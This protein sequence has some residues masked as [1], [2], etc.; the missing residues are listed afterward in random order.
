[1]ADEEVQGRQGAPAQT[2][3]APQD[4]ADAQ[5]Q[6]AEADGGGGAPLF[7]PEGFIMMSIAGAIDITGITLLCF[8][9]DDFGITDLIAY[10]TIGPWMLMR[11][12]GF[13]KPTA[14][15]GEAAQK[16][17]KL[18]KRLKWLRPAAFIG[19]LLPYLGALP[20]WSFMTYSEL[21]T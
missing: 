8:G 5:E 16:A 18:A 17:A 11:G 2:E 12:S 10:S 14:G 6:P 13:K 15:V 9:L 4:Q 21:Q 1:M 3:E 20:M 19:E 7:T